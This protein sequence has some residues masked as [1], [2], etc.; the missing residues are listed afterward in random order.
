[1]LMVV[2]LASYPRSGNTYF[3][4]L[5]H[6]LFGFETHSKYPVQGD[7]QHLPDDT[8]KMMSLTGRTGLDCDVGALRADLGWHFVKTHDLPDDDNSPAVVVVRDGRDAVISYAHFILKTEQGIERA[9]RDVFEATLEEIIRGDHFGGWSRNVNAWIERAGWES[10][11]RFEELIQIHWKSR[12]ALSRDWVSTVKLRACLLR[13][14]NCRR[15]S[16]GSSGRASRERG[17]TK[18]RRTFRNCFW[19][20][21]AKCCSDSDIRKE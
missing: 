19:N 11:V 16:H 4:V 18:C 13:S 14:R 17:H 20:D 8:K 10:L 6:R 9:D 7:P 15:Q 5:L 1:M 2:W 3:R 21:T 12:P